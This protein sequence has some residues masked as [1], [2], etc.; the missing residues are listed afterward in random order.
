M[1]I[2]LFGVDQSFSVSV[3][4]LT[5]KLAKS[6][7]AKLTLA[8]ISSSDSDQEAAEFILNN[9]SLLCKG[10]DVE[11]MYQS[12]E[13]LEEIM[14][15]LRKGQY[16]IVVF[17]DRRR[18]GL[19]ATEQ[20]QIVQKVILNTPTSVLLV[21][22]MS[23]KLEKMMICSGGTAISEPAIEL[24]AKIASKMEMETSLLHVEGPVPAFYNI[25]GV[26][27]EHL[28]NILDEKTPLAKHLIKCSEIFSGHALEV[29]KMIEHGVV[30]ETII[31]C[32]HKKEI[33]LVVLG[34]SW[35]KKKLSGFLMG[36]ITKELIKRMS[37]A[38]LI[39][40]I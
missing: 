38:I 22:Q 6:L 29:E 13:S 37:S 35:S 19:F 14:D 34:A 4:A 27:D 26:K 11:K 30:D 16:D 25:A 31:D 18:R 1:N 10:I 17:E 23:S 5:G 32:A 24:G 36:D 15:V 8:F 39:V 28:N 2:I 20:D 21:R 40:K 9:A 33:D 3:V 12:G 7:G